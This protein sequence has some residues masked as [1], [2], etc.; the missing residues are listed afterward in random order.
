MLKG[1]GPI[2]KYFGEGS[3]E[4]IM[5]ICEAEIGDSVFL[6]CG[7][8]IELESILSIARNKIANDLN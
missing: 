5:K 4:E 2:G 8:K 3:I 6:A 7:K 1:K